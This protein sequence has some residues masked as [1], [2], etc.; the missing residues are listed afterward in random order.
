MEFTGERYLSNFD[1]PEISYEHW[2]RY[3][4]ASQFV[5]DKMVLDIACGEGY[6]AF[7]LSKDAKRV[8]GIDISSEAVSHASSRYLQENLEFQVGSRRSISSRLDHHS[9]RPRVVRKGFHLHPHLHRY[10]QLHP[11]DHR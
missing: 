3:L 11:S 9:H 8:V 6:G 10:R 5:K 7:L 2:H 1:S 4:Y